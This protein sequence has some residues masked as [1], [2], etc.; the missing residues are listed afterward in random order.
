MIRFMLAIILYT[1]VCLGPAQAAI[2]TL[3]AD[4]DCLQANAGLGT[5]GAGGSGTG[6]AA[7]T[8]D[9]DTGD[10]SWV[11]SWSGLSGNIFAAHF[12][13]P[14]T[15]N[16]N[17][18]IEVP[19]DISSN[20]SLGMATLDAPQT[21]A[22]LAGLW[23]INLHTDNFPGGEIRG[24]VNVDSVNVIPVPAALWLFVTALIG[25]VGF[26]RRTSAKT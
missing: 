16:Q 17:A 23:Y 21:T 13:G 1:G 3:S 26:S 6:S 12:H 19:I 15:P 20:P 8:L 24:Q 18:G 22:L 9:T 25:L 2:A 4:L 11:V 14:A 7:M 10:F 5:C